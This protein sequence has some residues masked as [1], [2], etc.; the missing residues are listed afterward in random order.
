MPGVSISSRT[1][2]WQRT[3]TFGR[4]RSANGDLGGRCDSLGVDEPGGDDGPAP[5]DVTSLTV[6]NL[7]AQGTR[8]RG[9]NIYQARVYEEIDGLGFHALR[10][11]FISLMLSRGVSVEIVGQWVG[12]LDRNT[13]ATVYNHFFNTESVSVMASFKLFEAV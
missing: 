3:T 4:G 10:H 5:C 9:I 11:S 13:T 2:G 6:R 7:W 12:L 8:L 1:D